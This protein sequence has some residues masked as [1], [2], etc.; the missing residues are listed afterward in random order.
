MQAS[1]FQIN[2]PVTSGLVSLGPTLPFCCMWTL[3][4][5]F[6]VSELQETLPFLSAVALVITR[7]T[8]KLTSGKI[9]FSESEKVGMR[10]DTTM[11][12]Q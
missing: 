8:R 11:V 1:P 10:W 3:S 4:V 9:K 6:P 5:S 7:P 12:N 2:T